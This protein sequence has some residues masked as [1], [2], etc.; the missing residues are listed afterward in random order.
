MEGRMDLLKRFLLDEDGIMKTV[1]PIPV[2]ASKEEVEEAVV[3]G[4]IAL[5]D[6]GR[7]IISKAPWKE[8]DGKAMIETAT[9]R[10]ISCCGGSSRRDGNHQR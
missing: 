10:S 9:E 1:A 3:A 6:D 7:G 2:G 8:E 5:Y 4:K